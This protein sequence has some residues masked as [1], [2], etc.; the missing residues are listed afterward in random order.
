MA[1]ASGSVRLQRKLER[2]TAGGQSAPAPDKVESVRAVIPED[3]QTGAHALEALAASAIAQAQDLA[4]FA[5]REGAVVILFSDL[6]GSSVLY[7]TLGD[8]RALDLVRMHNELFRQEV[9]VHRGHE[10]K[11]L[12]DGFMVAF[13]SPHRA[14]QC[15]VAVQKSFRAFCERHPGT[16]I[17]IRIGLHVGEAINEASDLFGRTVIVASRIAAVAEGGRICVSSELHR[18]LSST[19]EFRFKVIGEKPLKGLTGVHGIYELEWRAGG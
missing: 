14:A 18:V 1:E 19:G 10:V 12:G 13:S 16:P 4:A 11:S 8:R 17:R 5:S 15:A 9:E 6:E 3:L 7:D 2:L